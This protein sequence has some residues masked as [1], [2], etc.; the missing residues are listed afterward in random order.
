[1]HIL[2]IEDDSALAEAIADYLSIQGAQCDFAYSGSSG[3]EMVKAHQF[4]LVILDLMLPRMNGYSVCRNLREQGYQTPVLMLTACDTDADQLEGFQA[5]VDD[6][7]AKPCSMPLL[8]ARLKALYTRAQQRAET[9]TIGSLTLYLNAQRAERE[10][11]ALKLTP[12]GWKILELLARNSPKV[13]SR[14]AIIDFAWEGDEVDAGNFNVQLHLLRKIVDKPF[15][16]ALIHTQ[17]GQGLFL[18]TLV[19]S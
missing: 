6:Y 5:G 11:Q 19:E 12:T 9:L 13:V 17:V 4:D 16:S 2:I 18:D 14:Q 8:W 15:N 3:V 10:K 1:M 7:V